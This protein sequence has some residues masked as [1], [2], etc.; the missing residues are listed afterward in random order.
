MTSNLVSFLRNSTPT[1]SEMT[2]G[3]TGT[4]AAAHSAAAAASSS[5]SNSRSG[6]LDGGFASLASESLPSLGITPSR[7]LWKRSVTELA[8]ANQSLVGRNPS[9]LPPQPTSDAQL[10]LGRRTDFSSLGAMGAAAAATARGGK[11]GKASSSGLKSALAMGG[12]IEAMLRSHRDGIL[13][14]VLK[15]EREETQRRLNEAVD[16]QLAEDWE[17]ERTWWK[18]ELVGNRNLADAT[19]VLGWKGAAGTGAAAATSAG[20]GRSRTENLL[21]ADYGTDTTIGSDRAGRITSGACDPRVIQDHL[22]IVKQI[23]PSSDPMWAVA[24][25]EKVAFL[26]QANG[27]YQVSWQLLGC[28]LPNMQN[29]IS[30]ALGSMVHL[31]RQYQ[32][33]IS[34]RVKSASLNGQDVSTS[35]RYGSRM[36]ETVAAYVKLVSGSTPGLW[37]IVYYCKCFRTCVSC[38]HRL[39]PGC[40]R[41]ILMCALFPFLLLLRSLGTNYLP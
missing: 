40:S 13:V 20:R 18:Q 4:A 32:N 29:P 25:F 7:P 31:C 30:G 12:G 1:L 11:A 39:V 28:M 3:F 10:L 5:S 14:G 17:I 22:T 27:G 19:N 33:I 37:E 6:G 36:A 16:R 35:I 2:L 26:D 8:A 41:L 21:V 38:S 9:Q 15:K 34:N 23:E 24:K